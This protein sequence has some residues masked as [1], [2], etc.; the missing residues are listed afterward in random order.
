MKKTED[1]NHPGGSK[2]PAAATAVT[3]SETPSTLIPSGARS[4][5]WPCTW[6]SLYRYPALWR[7]S[8]HRQGRR[9]PLLLSRCRCHQYLQAGNQRIKAAYSKTAHTTS[10][11]CAVFTEFKCQC[12]FLCLSC[13][14]V[15]LVGPL[16]IHVLS[17]QDPYAP[18]LVVIPGALLYSL[19]ILVGG[20]C[21]GLRRIERLR[22]ISAVLFGRTEHL[23]VVHLESFRS[24]PLDP[25][26]ALA[27]R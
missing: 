11:L 8:A 9:L 18:D 24:F 12:L 15:S 6:L 3:R 2:E 10:G 7:Q 4:A 27:C 26:P 14:S 21:T 23:V 17:I 5:P 19:S 25:D 20:L 16:G 22:P 13:D 1:Y